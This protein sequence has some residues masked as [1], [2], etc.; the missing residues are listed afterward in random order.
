[1]SNVSLE[2]IAH[3]KAIPDRIEST[4]MG[5]IERAS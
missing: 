3:A 2:Y 1:M 4:Q 5:A